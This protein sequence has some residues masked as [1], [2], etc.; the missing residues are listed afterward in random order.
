[1]LTTESAGEHLADLLVDGVS[2]APHVLARL[3]SCLGG[4]RL[5]IR[6]TVALLDPDVRKGLRSLPSPLPLAPST[7]ARYASLQLDPRDRELLLAVALRLRDDLDPLLDVDGRTPGEIARSRAGAHLELHAGGAAFADP[8]LAVWIRAST[9][10][11]TEAAVHG[12]LAAVFRARGDLVSE[13]WHRARASFRKDPV[14]A[15]ELIRIARL[16]SEAGHSDRA[17]ELADEAAAHAHGAVRDEARLVAGVSAVAAGYGA[18]AV[19]RL[20]PL[21]P[22]GTQRYRM[23]GLSALMVARAHLDGAVPDVAPE[24]LRPQG[25]DDGEDWYSWARACAFAAVL[26]AERGDRAALRAWLAA[27]REACGRV[28]A[29]QQLRDPVV[30]LAWLLVGDH[31]PDARF[32]A[33][34][35]EMLRALRAAVDGDID[36]G[37]RILATGD[38]G[39]LGESDAFIA[40]F[41]HS[42][43]LKA[44]RAVLEALLLTWRGDVWAARERLQRAS[45]ACPVAMPFAGLGVVLARRLDV[46]V[47]GRVGPIAA[48][49]TS[50][51]PAAVRVERLVDRGVCAYLAGSVDEA[52]AV[53][54][55]W[56]ERGSRGLTFTVPGLEEVGGDGAEVRARAVEPPEVGLAR[57]LRARI[58][59][60]SGPLWRAELDAVADAARTVVSPFDRGRIESMIGIRL[61]LREDVD[62]A[63]DHFRAAMSLFDESGAQAWSDATARRLA[64]LDGPTGAVSGGSDPLAIC[65]AVW[66]PVLT[67]RELDVAMLAARGASNRDIGD[68]LHVSVRTVEVHLGR[69]FAKLDVRTRVEL[70]VLA[71][72][73][74]RSR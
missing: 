37:L 52:S 65:R 26:C 48:A 6:E 45:L 53:I 25:C 9:E 40:G 21:F 19:D 5:A 71:H 41:E 15:P 13:G 74:G 4:D 8:S 55:L 34:T 47:Q 23:Q 64:E 72:R 22:D 20:G 42:P 43:L 49:L 18:E 35:G 54:R 16:L 12:R 73:T 29:D 62:A 69:A 33:D 3:H 66:G 51:L 67:A 36:L 7:R 32:D 28:G 1:M 39:L 46:M 2:C 60:L 58:G 44:Y 24:A 11:L 27:L 56:R 10:P 31:D 38:S 17:R 30:S 68:A 50:A 70:T 61:A 14:A 59:A 63:R 57:R